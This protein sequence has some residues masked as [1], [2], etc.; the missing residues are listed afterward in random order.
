MENPGGR[1]PAAA[2][3]ILRPREDGLPQCLGQTQTWLHLQ[4]VCSCQRSSGTL[5]SDLPRRGMSLLVPV[6]GV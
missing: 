1:H 2:D 5:T 6:E 3:P 4:P